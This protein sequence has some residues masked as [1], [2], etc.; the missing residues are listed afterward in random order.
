V[1]YINRITSRWNFQS[2]IP[3]HFNA[4]APGTPRDLQQAYA[5]AYKS[6]GLVPAKTAP[7]SNPFLDL[8]TNLLPR[9]LVPAKYPDSDMATLNAVN[10][11]LVSSGVAEK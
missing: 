4:P 9:P 3:A 5:F 2:I 6:T 10:G 1:D 8:L 7:S 11:F